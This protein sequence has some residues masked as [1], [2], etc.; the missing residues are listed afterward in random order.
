[1]AKWDVDA[2][3][4]QIKEVYAYFGLAMYHAQCLEQQ[5]VLILATKYGPGPTNMSNIDFEKLLDALSSR[6]FGELVKEIG[7]LA[8][9]SEDEEGRLKN[10]LFKRNQLVHRYFAERAIDFLSESGRE[11]MVKELQEVSECFCS[12]NELFAQR[13]LEYAETLGITQELVDLELNR[14]LADPGDP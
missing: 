4:E 3:P 13:M 11:M 5:L 14:L 1:M 6:T 2:D 7:R 12:L 8:S 10:A 9:L